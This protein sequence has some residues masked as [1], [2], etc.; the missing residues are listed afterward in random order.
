MRKIATL[1]GALGLALAAGTAHASGTLTVAYAGSMG[2][3]MDK[4]LGPSFAKAHG[5]EYRGI[6]QGAYGLARLIAAK[7]VQ[8]DV[9]I[10]INPGP[11]RILQ[12]AGLVDE[13]YPVASTAMVIAYNPKSKFAPR[14]EAAK[15][16]KGDWWK[17]LE[18][19]DLKFGRTD[20]ATD[21]QGQNIIFTLLLAQR[22][23]NQPDLSSKIIGDIVNKQ[24]IFAEPSAFARL[25]A[26]QIDASSGYEAA[27]ISAKLPYVKLPD[28]INLSNP[29]LAAEWYDKVQFSLK[30]KDGKDKVLKPEPMV[31][32]AAVVKGAQNPT[33][34]KA[35][36]DYLQQPEGQKLLRDHGY[37]EPKGGKM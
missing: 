19:P 36:V 27:T 8:A 25:E 3:V 37:N 1:F 5:D 30:D 15:S 23:Y 10:S 2:V 22:Y 12:Q 6:G 24:Q 32:Y 21:P 34:A 14:F 7:Q 4:F 9:F 18:S 26:G 13:A 35:F 31:Y 29:D 28:E 11:M 16:G 20:P 17:V 33:E